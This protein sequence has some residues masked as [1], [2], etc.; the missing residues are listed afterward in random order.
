MILANYKSDDVRI[1]SKEIK[2]LQR[3]PIG[4]VRPP[5][6]ATWLDA[7]IDTYGTFEGNFSI[8]LYS[9]LFTYSMLL[10]VKAVKMRAKFAASGLNSNA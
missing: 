5:N 6:H 9:L 1:K 8:C 4:A 10:H 7:G 3:G 2:F